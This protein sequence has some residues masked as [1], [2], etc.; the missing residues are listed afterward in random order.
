MGPDS[1]LYILDTF[2]DRQDHEISAYCLQAIS[3]YF[4]CLANGCSRMYKAT[5]IA[6]M[7]EAAGMQVE[8]VTGTLG[9]C[10]SLIVCRRR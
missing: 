4:T 10:S 7:A 3:L 9:I 1:R 5:D 2:W 6:A 8:R